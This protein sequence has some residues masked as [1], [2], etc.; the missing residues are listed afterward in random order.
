MLAAECLED[1]PPARTIVLDG[2]FVQDPMFGRILAALLPGARVLVNHDPFGTATGA[3]LL[4]GHETRDRPAPLDAEAPDTAGLPD[5]SS[6]RS[7]WRDLTRR[8]ESIA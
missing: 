6:Y 4:A 2:G 8:L 7:H 3:A 1:L 5:L